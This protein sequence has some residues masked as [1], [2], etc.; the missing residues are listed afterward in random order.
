MDTIEGY[1]ESNGYESTNLYKRTT[2]KA[3]GENRTISHATA[4]VLAHR[5]LAKMV[6]ENRFPQD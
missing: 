3:E 6:R 1:S 5:T 2:V 4:Y